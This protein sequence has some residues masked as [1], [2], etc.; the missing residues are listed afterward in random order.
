MREKGEN[1]MKEYVQVIL[2]MKK[3]RDFSVDVDNVHLIV[4][5]KTDV[6]IH[7]IMQISLY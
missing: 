6:L 4:Y 3:I 2:L 1:K 7:G 5:L